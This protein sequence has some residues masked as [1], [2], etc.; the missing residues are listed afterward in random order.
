MNLFLLSLSASEC[1]RWHCDKHVVKMILEIVQM[2]YTTWHVNNPDD[3][4]LF[5]APVCK[6]TGKPGYKRAHINH[7]MT[8]WMRTSRGNYRFAVRLAAALALEFR[9]RYEKH[10]SCTEH[11]LW[12]S[13]NTP[14]FDKREMTPVPQCM[15]DEYKVEGDSVKAYRNY[16][17]GDKSRFAKWK[18]RPVPPW[19]P[20]QE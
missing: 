6:S 18:K 11:V 7:P 1:S 19:W 4:R 12:L 8:K 9:F 10:H 5:G 16:Y 14:H 3:Q 13:S 2:L 17:I 20:Y 15:P